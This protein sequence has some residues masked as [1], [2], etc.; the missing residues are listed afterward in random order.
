MADQPKAGPGTREGRLAAYE[1]RLQENRLAAMRR[2]R[3][4]Q[5]RPIQPGPA[6]SSVG[7]PQPSNVPE[8]S[9]PCPARQEGDRVLG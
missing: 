2:A 4:V 3:E 1:Q 9:A 5:R 7:E 6:K 8:K